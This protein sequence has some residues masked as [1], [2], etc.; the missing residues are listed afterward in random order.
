M[1]VQVSVNANQV[2]AGGYSLVCGGDEQGVT[3]HV[4]FCNLWLKG[5]PMLMC[6]INI[7][8]ESLCTNSYK[9]MDWKGC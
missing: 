8:E 6:A 1:S 7:M 2:F 3:W 9:E 4:L 5:R